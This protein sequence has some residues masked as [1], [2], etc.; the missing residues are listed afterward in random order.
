MKKK[1]R[2]HELVKYIGLFILGS[3]GVL[4]MAGT[5]LEILILFLGIAIGNFVGEG[6]VFGL[7]LTIAPL[8]VGIGLVITFVGYVINKCVG[9]KNKKESNFDFEDDFQ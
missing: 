6:D 5:I 7:I 3:F 4:L 9:K 1:L 8:I 2:Y